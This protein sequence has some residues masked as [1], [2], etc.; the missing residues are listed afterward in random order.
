VSLT[1]SCN[2]QCTTFIRNARVNSASLLDFLP[3][4]SPITSHVPGM[5]RGMHHPIAASTNDVTISLVDYNFLR[6]SNISSSSFNQWTSLEESSIQLPDP[7]RHRLEPYFLSTFNQNPSNV[8]LQS[9]TAPFV[10]SPNSFN[11]GLSSQL[12][13]SATTC[14]ILQN[15]T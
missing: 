7:L 3:R 15:A 5:V 8:S 1:D 4:V 11:S 2:R 10:I 9:F 13:H 6:Y 12:C 14:K